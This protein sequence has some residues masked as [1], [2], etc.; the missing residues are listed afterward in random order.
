M[1]TERLTAED[2]LNKHDDRV[3]VYYKKALSGMEEFAAQEVEHKT[4]QLQEER[5]K[6]LSLILRCNNVYLPE[7]LQDDIDHF[8]HQL[9]QNNEG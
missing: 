5:D 8:F 3:Q 9:N 7:A 1:S 2:V 4:K 6:L